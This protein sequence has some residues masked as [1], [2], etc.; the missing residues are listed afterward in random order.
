MKT[1]LPK[2]YFQAENFL[3]GKESRRVPSIRETYI[4]WV[5][6]DSIACIY[7]ET[8]VVTFFKNGDVRLD[9]GEFFTPTTKRRMNQCLPGN[10]RVYQYNSYWFVSFSPPGSDIPFKDGML[11]RP[12]HS[13]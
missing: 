13:F 9:S 5:S 12:L 3:S 1:N 4:A 7:H 11:I 2:S 10:I 8:Q 6:E